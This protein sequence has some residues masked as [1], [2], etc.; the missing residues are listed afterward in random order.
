MPNYST[1][2]PDDDVKTT[3]AEAGMS[4][5]LIYALAASMAVGL[6][7][8]AGVII[9][10]IY[11]LTLHLKRGK[12]AMEFEGGAITDSSTSQREVNYGYYEV[13]DPIYEVI[14]TGSNH[15]GTQ[16]NMIMMENNDAYENIKFKETASHAPEGIDVAE[17]DNE[18]YVQIAIEP[19]MEHNNSYQ[20]SHFNL[21]FFVS[22]KE[23]TVTGTQNCYDKQSM[24]KLKNIQQTISCNEAPLSQNNEQ[25]EIYHQ[26]RSSIIP[27][28]VEDLDMNSTVTNSQNG[29]NKLACEQK[30]VC[31][32]I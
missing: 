28:C 29:S 30:G 15:F 20:A 22:Q 13:I 19:T 26:E 32:P 18:A 10:C 14:N 5:I 31:K 12:P 24:G 16:I 9:G 25:I 23:L 2:T 11:K 21:N 6:C 4:L 7:I 1:V 27:L 3:S 17:S 8:L